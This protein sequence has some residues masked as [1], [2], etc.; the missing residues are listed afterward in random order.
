M[1]F[2]SGIPTLCSN[3]GVPLRILSAAF[4]SLLAVLL[5]LLVL[6]AVLLPVP[7]F[8]QQDFLDP[9][10][11]FVLQVAMPDPLTLDVHFKVAP[12]YYMYR[13]RFTFRAE[14]EG[15]QVLAGSPVFPEGLVKYDPT[16]EQDLE[17]YYGTVTVRLPLMAGYSSSWTLLIGSQGCADAGLCYPPAEHRVQLQPVAGGY[18]ATGAFVAASV[19]APDQ[20][21]VRTTAQTGLADSGTG[22]FDRLAGLGD[23]AFAAELARS[24]TPQIILISALLGVLLSFTPC[25][26]PMVPI[27]L[28]ILVG[29]NDTAGQS[30]LAAQRGRS[31]V[32]RAR[33]RGFSLAALF[34]LGMSVVYTALG[35]AA[36]LLG[37][38]LAAWL[39]TPW[40]IVVFALL[41]AALA[42]AMFDVYTVQAPGALQSR[43][44]ALMARLPGGQY[45]AVFLMGMISSLIVGPCVAAPLAGVLLFI[46]QTGDVLLG[47]AALFAMAWGSGVLL[48]AVGAT[49]GVL[50]P[51]AG[52]WMERVKH[53][54]GVLLLATAW[55]MLNAVLP[56]ALMMLGWSV[57]ALW[58]AALLGSF[59]SWSGQGAGTLL[60][61]VVGLAFAV[62]SLLILVGLAGGGRSVLQPLKPFTGGQVAA[63]VPDVKSRF[64][65]VNSVQELDALLAQTNKPVLL[66]FYAD[67]C[68]SCIEMERFTFTDPE[69]AEKMSRML[70]VQ[71]DV[72]ANDAGHRALL[73][74][75]NL[76]GPPGIIFFDA[77][78]RE[79]PEVRVVGFM[80]APRFAAVLDKALRP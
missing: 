65:R 2:L 42:L 62:W 56:A 68:V 80:N 64:V 48:L 29:T 19:P 75:F 49:S 78:G 51:R 28:T 63:A 37:A 60:L 25:V 11:A 52:A 4:R 44:A 46:S 35:I 59:G 71:A 5:H 10:K 30:G 70:L 36:G 73:K 54:F 34:V 22:I 9:E 39:Q 43:L 57:L 66:D 53:V 50:K 72:T 15:A 76:F 14:P 31:S 16:F 1:M 74:R 23:T 67:W 45:G 7:S 27:L 33:W 21:G 32:H 17:V 18:S 38:S 12:E 40:V 26:L 58:L 13:E 8:A 69:V 6:A 3:A 41:L 47:G 20:T 24:S 61:K 79:L 77:R 55:W